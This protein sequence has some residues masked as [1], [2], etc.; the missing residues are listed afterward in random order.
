[1]AALCQSRPNAPQQRTSL[2]DHLVGKQLNRVRYFNAKRPGRL[3]VDDELE[4]G[5]ALFVADI[6]FGHGSGFSRLLVP[7]LNGPEILGALPNER[8]APASQLWPPWLSSLLV[9]YVL[10]SSREALA[11]PLAQQ[12]LILAKCWSEWQDLNLRPP[13]PERGALPDCATRRGG[14]VLMFCWKARLGKATLA[15]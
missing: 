15:K 6:K 10:P 14:V 3:Q 13:R 8:H 4:F 9:A 2:F 11:H 12:V 7:R 1:M 5:S